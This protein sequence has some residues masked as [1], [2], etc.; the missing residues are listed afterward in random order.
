V[1]ITEMPEPHPMAMGL[2]FKDQGPRFRDRQIHYFKN[3]FTG[4]VYQLRAHVNK[5]FW[6]YSIYKVYK[7][8]LL[9]KEWTETDKVADDLQ[10]YACWKKLNELLY[11]L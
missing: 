5:G 11:T 7:V 4:V 1:K 10:D 6:T 2:L 8:P 3:P 9:S